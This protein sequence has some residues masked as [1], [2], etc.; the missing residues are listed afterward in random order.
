MSTFDGSVTSRYRYRSVLSATGSW[1]ISGASR[2]LDAWTLGALLSTTGR[3][4]V[5]TAA[6]RDLRL[7]LYAPH[8][9]TPRARGVPCPDAYGVAPGAKAPPIG[10]VAAS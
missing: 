7:R 5:A 6:A 10:F 2:W 8:L 3:M 4:A 9:F 1:E